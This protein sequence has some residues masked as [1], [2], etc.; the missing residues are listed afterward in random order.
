MDNLSGDI[1]AMVF[2]RSIK[3]DVGEFSFDSRMLGVLMEMDGKLT[4]ANISAKIGLNMSEIRVAVS[5]LAQIGLIEAVASSV[6]SVDKDFLDYLKTQLSLAIGPVAN[7]LI[8]DEV[9][10]LGYS[11]S[12]F[13]ATRAADL[14]Q[15]LAKEI[16]REDKRVIFQKNMVTKIKEKRY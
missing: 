9:A 7:L 4:L 2:K 1:S 5:K 8:E 15:L 3:T 16:Q 10:D 11:T 13:P 14:V 6:A 12:Q